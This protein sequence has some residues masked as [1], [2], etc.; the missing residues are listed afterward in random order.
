MRLEKIK[1]SGFKSFVDP[2]TVHLTSNLIGIV[3]PNGCGKSN[4]IDAVRWVMGESSAKHLRGGSMVDVI[5]NGSATRQPVSHASVELFFDNHDGELGG[6]YAQYA[7]I[8]V[9]RQLNREGQS[10]YFLNNLRCRRRDIVDIFLGT[11]LGARSYAIIEQG[12]ISKMVESKPE[13]LREHIEEAAGISKYK[14]RRHEAEIRIRHTREN[15]DRLNDIRTEVEKQ[16]RRLKSQA[17]KAETFKQLKQEERQCRVELLALRWQGYDGEVSGY[18]N[19]IKQIAETHNKSSVQQIELKATITTTQALLSKHRES[20]TQQ[21]EHYY[22]SVAQFDQLAQKIDHVSQNNERL[23]LEITRLRG[24]EKN[25]VIEIAADKQQLQKCLDESSAAK[26][27]Y[28][29]AAEKEL[30]LSTH[31]QEALAR[32]QQWQDEWG[33]FSDRYGTVKGQIEVQQSKVIQFERQHTQTQHQLI[34]LQNEKK[35]LSDTTIQFEIEALGQSIEG[36]SSKQAEFRQQLEQQVEEITQCRQQVKNNRDALNV[37]NAQEHAL[38]G[39]IESLILLQQHSM[40]KKNKKLV[41]W[42]QSH[43]LMNEKRLAEMI[44]VDQGWELAVEMVLTRCL[45]AIYVDDLDHYV[46]ALESLED[47]TLTLFTGSFE[48]RH[49]SEIPLPLLIDK[50]RVPKG[51]AVFLEDIYCADTLRDAFNQMGNLSQHESIITPKGI[52]LGNGWVKLTQ[53]N[54]PQQG[55]LQREKELRALKQEQSLL[56]ATLREQENSLASFENRLKHAEEQRE[57]FQQKDK[58]IAEELTARSAEFSASSARLEQQSRR[59]EQV[60]RDIDVMTRQLADVDL[61]IKHSNEE[62][63]Q[64]VGLMAGLEIEKQDLGLQ[65]DRL[66]D[67]WQQA[68]QQSVQAKQIVVELQ[69]RIE[70]LQNTQNLIQKQIDRLSE[71]SKQ[72][73]DRLLELEDKYK[74]SIGPLSHDKSTLAELDSKKKQD[75]VTVQNMTD[76][77]QEMESMLHKHVGDED[78]LDQQI[79]GFKEELNRHRLLQEES[80]IRQKTVDEQLAELNASVTAIIKICP[81]DAEEHSWKRKLDDLVSAIEKLGAI[82]LTAIEEFDAEQ[83]RM[84][85]LNEQYADLDE[86]MDKL[87]QAIHKIDQETQICFK[88]TF[89][90]INLGLQKKFEKLFSGGRAYLELTEGDALEAGVNIVAQPPGKKTRSIH[91]LSGGEKALT[92]V[93]LVFSFFDLN[94]APF[95]MLDEVD[96]PLDDTNVARFSKLVEEMSENVQLVFISHNKATMEI[97]KQLAGV[98]MRESGVSRMVSVDIDEALDLVES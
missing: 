63:V 91:L 70:S 79:N 33:T 61:A 53:S 58:L 6:V 73:D 15:L 66:Q 11:G 20:L 39:K 51:A 21:Q 72:D 78:R 55:I 18:E 80:K 40:G 5:F 44:E 94:P 74:A 87:E 26:A 90:A 19:K 95:C 96:A 41:Q 98:T 3:G 52:W 31:A 89:D 17:K 43:A 4:I 23:Q 81:E 57:F 68:N 64:A 86:A 9:K 47:E 67:K 75:H 27:D 13:E 29:R 25:V 56:D 59:L 30:Q 8:S 50:I 54:S 85:F 65:K 7:Q 69:G 82:N 77:L 24:Q 76:Q 83:Q 62:K 12:T 49:Q 34:Q 48:G 2:T 37:L 16:L 60:L 93:A 84:N 10:V 28:Q 14:E 36:I 92:A 42:L 97:A 32:Q 1:L 46:D 38:N 71:M 45:D 88:E 22:Q 35:E